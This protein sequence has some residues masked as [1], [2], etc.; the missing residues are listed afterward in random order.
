[1]KTTNTN[2]NPTFKEVID[3]DVVS[4]DVTRGYYESQAFRKD[5][6][7]LILLSKIVGEES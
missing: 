2:E 7:I 6:I 1:M 5:Q 3:L 4:P